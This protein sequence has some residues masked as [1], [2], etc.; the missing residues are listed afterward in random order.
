[1]GFWGF[2]VLG[3]RANVQKVDLLLYLLKLA[4]HYQIDLFLSL[5][6]LFNA[7]SKL[8]KLLLVFRSNRGEPVLFFLLI[9]LLLLS[10][11][12]DLKRLLL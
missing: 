7:L 12:L 2:G 5:L 4:L 10:L 3:F 9:R 6:E 1:M 11:I 8:A